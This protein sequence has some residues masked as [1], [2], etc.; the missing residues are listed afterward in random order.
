MNQELI[1]NNLFLAE[2][3]SWIFNYG[4]VYTYMLSDFLGFIN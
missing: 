3:L 1:R 4:F 2:M